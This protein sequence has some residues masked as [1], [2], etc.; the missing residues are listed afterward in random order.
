MPSLPSLVLKSTTQTLG[1]HEY[2][3]GI[4]RH[5]E[6]PTRTVSHDATHGS[7]SLT[8]TILE[9]VNRTIQLVSIHNSEALVCIAG[10][11]HFHAMFPGRTPDCLTGI[12]KVLISRQVPV[13]QF[14]TTDGAGD[15][16]I[17]VKLRSS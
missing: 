6:F 12:L 15:T 16:E 17:R 13:T 2:R 3:N 7:T 5:I 11:Q 14:L 4:L 1:Q 10:T 8:A 9:K